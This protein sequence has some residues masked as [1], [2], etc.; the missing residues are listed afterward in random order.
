MIRQRFW[1]ARGRIIDKLRYINE[2]Y[3][4]HGAAMSRALNLQEAWMAEMRQ[5][6][7]DWQV[8]YAERCNVLEVKDGD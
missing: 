2:S 1:I 4:D 3:T 6:S 5:T 7:I 8:G